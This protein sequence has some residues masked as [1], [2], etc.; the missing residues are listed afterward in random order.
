[1]KFINIE[2]YENVC[3]G[4]WLVTCRWTNMSNP[5]GAFFQTFVNDIR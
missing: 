1:V 3:A 2:L 5:V 4:F